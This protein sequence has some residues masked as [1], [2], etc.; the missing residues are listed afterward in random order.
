MKALAELVGDE[1]RFPATLLHVNLADTK[2]RNAHLGHGRVDGDI[3]AFD[4]VLRAATTR[5]W[6]VAAA[7]VGWRSATSK[8]RCWLPTCAPDT[9]TVSP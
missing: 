7:T 3:R 8:P 5:A 2:R 9:R 4:A 1:A 6:C